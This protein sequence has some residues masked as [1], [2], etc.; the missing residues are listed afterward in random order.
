[1]AQ[2]DFYGTGISATNWSRSHLP[3]ILIVA[4]NTSHYQEFDLN[5][6]VA[7]DASIGNALSVTVV[8]S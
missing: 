6:D 2:L 7:A 4:Q 1:M 8:R 5:D 3:D